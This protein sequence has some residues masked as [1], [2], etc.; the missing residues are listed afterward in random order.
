MRNSQPQLRK[1]LLLA[2]S[3]GIVLVLVTQ[4]HYLTAFGLVTTSSW[5]GENIVK[6]L[7]QS[8]ALPQET[9]DQASQTDPCY[10]ELLH[11]ANL[12]FYPASDY[13]TCTAGYT[14]VTTGVAVHDNPTKQGVEGTDYNFN[15]GKRLYLAKKWNSL[16]TYLV[17]HDPISVLRV[18]PATASQFFGDVT[19]F[20]FIADNYPAGY[21]IWRWYRPLNTLLPIAGWSFILLGAAAFLSIA[22]LSRRFS[23]PFWF[24]LSLLI[25]HALCSM[26]LE[27]GENERFAAEAYPLVLTLAAFAISLIWGRLRLP[28]ATSSHSVVRQ[29]QHKS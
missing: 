28:A 12:F 2:A 24:A 16:A 26:F 6:A 23:Y 29:G 7:A 11:G 15:E 25:Y 17:L 21:G 20:Q 13:P 18:G 19:K 1:W 27:S 22:R 14:A 4:L 8:G 10:H 3:P 9:R 5:S